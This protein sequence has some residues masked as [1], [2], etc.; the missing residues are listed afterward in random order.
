MPTAF[1]FDALEHEYFLAGG[2]KVWSIT[3][4]I[5]RCGLIDT[6]WFTEE[7]KIRGTAVHDLTAAYD[8]GALDPDT[9]RSKYRGWLLGHVAATKILKPTW[10]HI[11]EPMVHGRLR[12]GGRP[13]R[14][15]RVFKL[16][17]IVEI[18]SGAVEKCHQVQTAL[19]AILV[20]AESGTP[21][22]PEHWQRMALYLK[23]NG[24]YSLVHHRDRRDFDEARRII[25]RCCC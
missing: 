2:D 7:S 11:E 5:E 20:S 6:E 23:P 10:R 19:Q 22:P 13:D 1:R 24:A 25:K 21:L 12:F 9:C 17:T 4:M 15:G 3:Q 14:V 18:K 16:H 8:L